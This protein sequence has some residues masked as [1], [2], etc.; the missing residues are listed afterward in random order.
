MGAVYCAP[1]MNLS[2]VIPVC[3]E[4]DNVQPLAREIQ[5]ALAGHGPFEIIFVDDGS[6]D[7]TAAAACAARA[8]GIPEIRLLQH[9]RRSGQSAAVWTGV[10]A[11]RA[12]WIA[13]LDGDGK[14]HPA[15]MPVMREAL[16]PGD[17][18]LRLIMG[19]RRASRKDTW[20]RK[21]SS[22]VAN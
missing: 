5:A 15:D 14:T 10:R 3:N 16:R 8:A 7:A 2:V 22:L 18:A 12:D 21:V 17:E 6:T 13:T 20:L 11:A 19:N 9:S 4:A 1:A